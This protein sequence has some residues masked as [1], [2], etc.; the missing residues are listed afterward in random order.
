MR[1]STAF[2]YGNLPAHNVAP[3]ISLSLSLFLSEMCVM[4]GSTRTASRSEGV[5]KQ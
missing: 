4:G 5:T 3:A 2:E 1:K